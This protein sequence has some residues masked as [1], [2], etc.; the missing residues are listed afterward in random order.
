MGG[1]TRPGKASQTG[2]GKLGPWIASPAKASDRL[3]QS[4]PRL[5][6][7]KARLGESQGRIAHGQVKTRLGKRE[8]PWKAQL[9]VSLDHPRSVSTA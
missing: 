1:N 9:L 2:L 8:L 3:G 4:G 5:N 6:Q 7:A